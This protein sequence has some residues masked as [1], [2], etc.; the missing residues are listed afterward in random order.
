MW[1]S[2]SIASSCVCGTGRL[3][4]FC[5]GR[6]GRTFSLHS[7]FDLFSGKRGCSNLHCFACWLMLCLWERWAWCEVNSCALQYHSIPFFF[8][9]LF[10]LFHCVILYCLGV[11]L[12]GGSSSVWCDVITCVVRSC[13]RRMNSPI[14]IKQESE[15]VIYSL[16]ITQH[17]L[18]LS[19]CVPKTL[20]SLI[21]YPFRVGKTKA[22]K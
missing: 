4:Q 3:W 19:N 13:Q 9:F 11:K 8:L 5:S 15:E 7:L 22:P 14:L 17:Q 10:P 16:E 6:T 20:Y 2:F 21:L 1:E 12:G 18:V